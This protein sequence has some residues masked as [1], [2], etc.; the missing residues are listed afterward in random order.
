MESL[1]LAHR[2]AEIIVDK[3][4]EDVLI[5]DLQE[6][7]MFTDYFV[8]CS[9]TSRRQLYAL[10]SALRE[11]LKQTDER[12]LALNVEG[13]AESG[14][15]LVDYNSVIVHLFDSEMRD[16]YRLEELWKNGRVVARIQ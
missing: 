13:E 3:Q 1:E 8:I 12:I 14:W 2:I 15:I 4:G 5:L 6:V 9:G 10:Q 16:F 11:E 7:T